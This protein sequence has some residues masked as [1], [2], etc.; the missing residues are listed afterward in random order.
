M[1]LSPARGM[2]GIA[3]DDIGGI[4]AQAFADPD[5]WIGRELELAGDEHTLPGYAKA[6][7]RALGV[8]VEYVQ[9]PWEAIREQSEDL[10]RMYDFFE[11]VG[12]QADTRALRAEYPP[13]HTFEQWIADG[14]LSALRKAA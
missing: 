1:P 6:M 2:Q 8:P 4:V 10:Y 11:R 7:A 5:A 9:M 12:Y 14:G 3:A 13:L